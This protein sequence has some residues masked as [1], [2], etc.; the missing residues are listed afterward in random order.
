MHVDVPFWVQH[1]GYLGIFLMLL[2]EMIGIPFPGETILVLAGIEWSRGDLKLVPLLCFATLASVIGCSVAY[3]L[4]RSFGRSI[5]ERFGPLVGLT[6]AKIER[7]EAH[8]HRYQVMVVLFAKFVAG[9]RVLATYLAGINRMPFSLFSLYNALGS[10][11]W[12][13]SFVVFGKYLETA[14]KKF[15]HV[16][17]RHWLPVL[18]FGVAVGIVLAASKKRKQRRL[19]V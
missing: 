3:G 5:L 12:V 11:V 10:L 8:F 6:R 17:Y 1:Y 2:A 15:H 13:T 16:F 14:W 19:S 7:A 9:V 18:L 4:G